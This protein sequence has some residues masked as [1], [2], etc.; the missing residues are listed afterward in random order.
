MNSDWLGMRFRIAKSPR[1][2]ALGEVGNISNSNDIAKVSNAR[3]G[4]SR[5]INTMP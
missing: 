2:S 3:V 5:L 1:I 4:D